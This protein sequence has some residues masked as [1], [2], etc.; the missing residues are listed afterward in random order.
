MD[1]DKLLRYLKNGKTKGLEVMIQR[2]TP[3]VSTIV[4]NIIGE[5]M[6]MMDV[7]EVTA[8]VFLSVWEH[9]DVIVPEK[10]KA[11]L[12]AVARNKAKSKL[13]ECRMSVSLDEDCIEIPD[14]SFALG[15]LKA[16]D[17]AEISKAIDKLGMPHREI[18]L[19]YYY[20][21]QTTGQI[22]EDMNLNKSTVQ[23]YLCRGREKLKQILLEGGFIYEG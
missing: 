23:T 7:E 21:Y 15:I 2:Y 13:R 8:D 10:L 4:Y 18:F 6:T 11:Y 14:D 12:A 17:A 20:Y 3:F 5:K 1:D 22:A 19:R 9:A 16:E